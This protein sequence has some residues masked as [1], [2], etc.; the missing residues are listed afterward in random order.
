MS[1]TFI[2]AYFLENDIV[3]D[4]RGIVA[5]S[6]VDALMYVLNKAA[7][8]VASGYRIAPF[9]PTRQPLGFGVSMRSAAL[10][11]SAGP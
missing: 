6:K 5:T 9:T 11:R 3:S 1:L 8:H 10:E 7:K 4:K 2:I